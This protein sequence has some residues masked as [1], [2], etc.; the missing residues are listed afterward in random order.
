MAID[1]KL[2]KDLQERRKAALLGGGKDK[3]EKRREA[4]ILPARERAGLRERRTPCDS[5]RRLAATVCRNQS[6]GTELLDA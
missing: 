6:A 1:P 5:D 4:G 3:Q 2:L